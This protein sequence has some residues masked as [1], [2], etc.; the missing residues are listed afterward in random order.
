VAGNHFTWPKGTRSCWQTMWVVS[1]NTMIGS[2]TL[3]CLVL[4]A[5]WDSHSLECFASEHNT[6]L[7]RS[8]AVSGVLELKWRILS[9]FAGEVRLWLVGS[10]VSCL[11]CNSTGDNMCSWGTLVIPLWKSA[12]FW[13]LLCPNGCHLAPFKLIFPFYQGILLPRLSG[14]NVG[15][16]MTWILSV[17]G[18]LWFLRSRTTI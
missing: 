9:Q 14:N 13:P 2:S 11:L 10:S 17:S 6:Q 18:I 1:E 7:P 16:A 8:T 15:D 12:P 5:A 3:S 4:Y